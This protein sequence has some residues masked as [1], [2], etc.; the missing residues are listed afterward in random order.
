MQDSKIIE[1]YWQRSES[2][3]AET[4]TQYGRYCHKIAYNIL[5]SDEDSEECVND[6]YVKAWET[7][8]P[9]RPDSLCA[10]L[11][12]ITRNIALDR[13]DMQRAQ[14][15]SGITELALDEL[16]EC[17][18][19]TEAELPPSEE[20]ALRT[21]INGFLASLPKRTRIVFM[22][23]YWYMCSIGDIAEDLGMSESNVKVTLLR[24]RERFK[25]HLEREGIVI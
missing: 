9:K 19:D 7:M 2:A 10:Y 15:R 12:R 21:A 16:G 22:R 18:P 23:R 11:G 1:L 24:A 20:I 6:T 5:Y 25:Q 14:K 13:Y 17:I 4:Q 8:P 3:I